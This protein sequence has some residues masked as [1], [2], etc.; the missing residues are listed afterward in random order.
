MNFNPSDKRFDSSTCFD[1]AHTLYDMSSKTN[2]F[3]DKISGIGVRYVDDKSGKDF[4]DFARDDLNLNNKTTNIVIP[5]GLVSDTKHSEYGDYRIIGV[6]L[7]N[8]MWRMTVAESQVNINNKTAEL[9]LS[10]N[11]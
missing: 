10:T 11:R 7:D 6:P 9:N 2:N 1:M 4:K 3:L 8:K 5:K